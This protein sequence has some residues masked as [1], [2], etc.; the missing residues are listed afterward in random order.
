MIPA[1]AALLAAASSAPAAVTPYSWI[2]FGEANS[3]FVDSSGNNRNFNLA[4]S[5]GNSGNPGAFLVPTGVAGP[6]G[7]DPNLASTVAS[8]WGSLNRREAAMW[9]DPWTF[10][11]T[12]YVL[13]A[14]ILPIGTGGTQENVNSQ[15]ASTGDS[16]GVAFRTLFDG[17]PSDRESGEITLTLVAFAPGELLEVGE[18]VIVSRTKWTHVAAVNDNGVLTLYVNGVATGDPVEFA[19]ASVG[20]AF[21]GGG[22]GTYNPFHGYIDEVRYSTFAPGQFQ[23]SDLLTRPPGPG[24]LNQPAAATVWDGGAAP[25]EVRVARDDST[26]YQW[27]L[28]GT[29]I[30]GGTSAELYLPAVT[31]AANGNVYSVDVTS[32]G[33]T[34]PGAGAELTVV[35]VRTDDTAFYRA[36]ILEETSLFAYYPV[37]GDT[38]TALTNTRNAALNGT[39]DAVVSYDGRTDRSY[40]QRAL[41]FRR[42]GG[43]RVPAN[44]AFDFPGGT[45]TVEAIIYLEP[46]VTAG[47]ATI[48]SVAD[49]EA[50]Y[51]RFY[52][53]LDGGSLAYDDDQL[54]APLTWAVPASLKGRFAHVALTFGGGQMT[55]YVD[56]ESL[57]SKPLSSFGYI[58]GLPGNIGSAGTDFDGVVQ[59]PWLGTIDEL[60]VYSTALPALTMAVHNSRFRFGTAVTAPEIASQPSGSFSLLA[61]GAP[62]FRVVATGTAPLSYQWKHNGAD[63]TDN[64]TATTATL[65]L[66]GA[67]AAMSGEYTVTVSNPQGSVVS[68]PFTVTFVPPPDAYSALV[69]ED[70]PS[71]YWRLNETTGTAVKDYAGGLDGIYSPTV[72]PGEEGPPGIHPDTAVKFPGNADP[73]GNA[74]IPF[75]PTI[76]PAGPF[77]IECW[78]KPSQSGQ[79]SLAV[80]AS[81]NRDTGRAGYAIYQGLNGSFWEVH[82]G[83]GET[84][85][86]LQG[87]PEPAAG[88]WDHIVATWDGNNLARMYVN[89]TL[90]STVEA[91]PLRPN[92]SVPLEIGSRFHGGVPYNGTVDEVAIYNHELSVEQIRKHWSV[93]WIPAVITQPPPAAVSATEASTITLSAEVSG[94]PNTYQWLRNGVPLEAGENPDGSPHFPQGVNSPQLVI[95][96]ITQADAGTYRLVVTNPLGE[97]QSPNVVVTFVPDLT[98]PVVSRVVADGSLHRVRVEFDRPVTAQTAGVAANYTFSGGLTATAVALTVDPSVVNVITNGLTPGQEY[99]LTVSNVKDQRAGG[100]LIGPNETA[101]RAPVM[102]NGALALDFYAGIPGN[103]VVELQSDFQWPDGV[104]RSLAL[105]GFTTMPLTNGDL[106]TNPDFG[107]LGSN[108]GMRI[109]GWITPEVS[110]TYTF[111]LRSDDAS[112][113]WLSPDSDPEKAVIIAYEEGCCDPFKEPGGTATETSEPVTLTAGT[114]YYVEVLCKEG[115][116]GDYV[117]VAWRSDDDTTPAAQLSPISGSVLSS[118]AVSAG[119]TPLPGLHTPVLTSGEVTLTWDGAGTLEESTDLSLWTPVPGNP[120]SPYTT[121]AGGRKF[122]RLVE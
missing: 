71:A 50:V 47:E 92:L 78:V 55:A 118:Y 110:G 84:V 28:D 51:F 49:Q 4:F 63:V 54:E 27:K 95:S 122:Y 86:F 80:L 33:V 7:G 36:A 26:T 41:R 120:A 98:P 109:Y 45:G 75:S 23:V 104:L 88:R 52:A 1:G 53:G 18:P 111:F 3:L 42:D 44:P 66:N 37:D 39:L 9:Q 116:G 8:L 96:G 119:A 62:A 64:P 70:N 60:A 25:F 76:N 30:D 21:V 22:A 112:E 103:S 89:G 117:E 74:V 15:I 100:N 19:K 106:A 56:G 11:A 35:P 32:D 6:L 97:Q 17:D 69:L 48:F 12:N 107:P 115:I 38:G 59:S 16:T 85:M 10:P 91:S 40:G 121:P 43:V 82:F 102:R 29:A 79:N 81:Q 13:E 14:W 46:T 20:S 34:V 77:S 83:T 57:G 94:F 90:V 68:Q 114:R 67:T 101:F 58:T 93:A 113:L 61:G 87:G 99:T 65:V 5:T 31:A 72:I 108:Y 24:I 73:V 105:T 2:R